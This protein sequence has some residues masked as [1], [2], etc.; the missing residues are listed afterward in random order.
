VAEQD[1]VNGRLLKPEEAK[2]YISSEAGLQNVQL[3]AVPAN[4]ID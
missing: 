3:R 2:S 1:V 4:E